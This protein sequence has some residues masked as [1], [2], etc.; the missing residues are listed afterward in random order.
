MEGS[1]GNARD[2]GNQYLDLRRE[3]D[4]VGFRKIGVRTRGYKIVLPNLQTYLRMRFDRVALRQELLELTPNRRIKLLKE[5]RKGLEI[6]WTMVGS[7]SN[8][9]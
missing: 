8:G 3:L 4:E 9:T 1:T 2:L 7:R 5:L 6:L